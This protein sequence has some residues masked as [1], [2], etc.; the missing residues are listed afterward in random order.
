MTEKQL[1]KAEQSAKAK[2]AKAQNNYSDTFRV[3]QRDFT[4]GSIPKDY[5]LNNLSKFYTITNFW[6]VVYEQKLWNVD[7]FHRLKNHN[8]KDPQWG[9]L[10]RLEM[11][12]EEVLL[13]IKRCY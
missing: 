7:L 12:F 13:L 1:Y 6:R 11:E 4:D 2:W 3:L 5:E 9:L 10:V 8:A